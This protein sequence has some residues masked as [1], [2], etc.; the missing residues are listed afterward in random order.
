MGLSIRA[1]SA[2]VTRALSFL[3]VVVLIAFLSGCA[4]GGKRP[5]FYPNFHLESIG[6]EQAERDTDAC[7]AL[8][9]R[10]GVDRTKDGE[11]GTKAAK[12]GVLGGVSAGVWGL[13][14]GGNAAERAAAGAAAGAATG[15]TVGAFDSAELSPTFKSFVQRC[16]SERGYDVIGWE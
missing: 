13:V 3:T 16:L 7:M 12:G 5:V 10:Y 2:S 1:L 15:A 8:A 4:S 14:R 11:V 6:R 9:D